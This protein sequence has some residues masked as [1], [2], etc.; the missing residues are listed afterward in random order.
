LNHL[1][2]RRVSEIAKRLK[3]EASFSP[4][5]LAAVGRRVPIKD[6]PTAF[7]QCARSRRMR[8]DGAQT[9]C[10]RFQDRQS[11][12]AGVWRCKTPSVI[13]GTPS[14]SSGE[15]LFSQ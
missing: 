7:K 4:R 10:N 8:E 5:I 12:Q 13:F 15:L 3:V 1:S 14:D 9:R 6:I 11:S 2:S